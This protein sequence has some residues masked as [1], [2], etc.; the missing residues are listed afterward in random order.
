MADDKIQTIALSKL[1]A[2]LAEKHEMSKKAAGEFLGAFVE[3]TVKNLKKGHKV[4]VTGL[5]IFQVKKRPARMGRN[6]A[7]GEAI[8]IKASKKLAFRAAKEVKDAI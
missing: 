7:T 5:G 2:E 1:A 3:L 8:K 6:P 4:R